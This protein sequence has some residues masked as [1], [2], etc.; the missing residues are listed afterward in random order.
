MPARRRRPRHLRDLRQHRGRVPAEV[1]HPDHRCRVRMRPDRH[2]RA[3]Q[4]GEG[5]HRGAG[6][7]QP[8][9]D[10]QPP[11]RRRDDP[12]V[13]VR[14]GGAGP[15]RAARTRVRARLLRVQLD[16]DALA[17]L[18][19]LHVADAGLRGAEGDRS[20]HLRGRGDEVLRPRR[21][22]RARRRRARDPRLRDLRGLR[23]RREARSR[24]AVH[25]QRQHR[26]LRARRHPQLELPVARAA[27]AAQ[28]ARDERLAMLVPECGHRRRVRRARP[29]PAL[30]LGA[31]RLPG[32]AQREGQGLRQ[33]VP[34]AADRDQG[35][36]ARER[37]RPLRP[38]RQRRSGP[39]QRPRTGRR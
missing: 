11:R 8:G 31:D 30:R 33:L 1:A 36:R 38:V 27:R 32:R 18:E 29:G 14:R 22:R 17:V 15:R 34:G 5:E 26:A 20:A 12:G 6:R 37:P 9:A 10:R 4:R 23:Q 7:D 24:R 19:V 35:A 3:V 21:R 2:D 39:R 16:L 25:G 13:P 28:A